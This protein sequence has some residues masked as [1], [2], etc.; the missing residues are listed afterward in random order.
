MKEGRIR[1]EYLYIILA[2][3]YGWLIFAVFFADFHTIL[4]F[5]YVALLGKT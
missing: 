4:F 1:F 2:Y 3:N 5:H